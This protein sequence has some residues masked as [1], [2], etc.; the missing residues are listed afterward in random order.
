MFKGGID[1]SVDAGADAAILQAYSNKAEDKS[2]LD[3][4][5]KNE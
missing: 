1:V 5:V 2:Q 4:Q 3:D